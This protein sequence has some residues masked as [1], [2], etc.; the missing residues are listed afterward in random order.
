MAAPVTAAV[1]LGSNVGDRAAHL[2]RALGAMA[3]L[4][5]TDVLHASVFFETAAVRVGTADPGGPYL[6]AAAVIETNLSPREL[7]AA[8]HKIEAAQGRD[9]TLP[10]GSPRP[11]D[12]DLLVYADRVIND[13]DLVVPHPRITER[14]F[15]LEPLAEIAPD[16]PVPPSGRTVAA[17]L[18]ELRSSSSPAD[19]GTAR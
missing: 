1:A 11:L 6:N 8:L 18:A 10:R 3:A 19:P 14:A 16:L 7:L 15:V 9:R 4:P 5:G 2:G 12:L 17:L 13:G